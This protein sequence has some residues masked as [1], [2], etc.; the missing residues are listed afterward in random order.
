MFLTLEEHWVCFEHHLTYLICELYF[1][2]LTEK[3]GIR[4]CGWL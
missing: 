2:L 1:C 3:G 4:S